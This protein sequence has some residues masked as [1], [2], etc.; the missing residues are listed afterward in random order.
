MEEEDSVAQP[1]EDGEMTARAWHLSLA[2]DGTGYCGWQVQDNQRTVQGELLKRLRLLFQSPELRLQG[3]SRTDSGVH[4]LDQHACFTAATSKDITPEWLLHKLNRW[5]PEDIIIKGVEIAP[6]GFNP[7]FD[8]F[9]KAYT[10]CISPGAKV[11]PMAARYVWK[12]PR[13]LDL[14]AMKKAAAYLEGEH[15]FA[16]FAANP[17]REIGSTVRKLYRLEV[18]ERGGLVFIVAVG[19][20]FLYKMVRGLAGY[21]AHVGFGYAASE[22]AL[23]VLEA[24]NRSAAADSAPSKGLFLARVFW[25]PDEWRTYEPVLPPFSI[26]AL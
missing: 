20:S 16:S 18:M 12:T 8:N 10:Y 13:P 22:D 25:K 26:D 6:D 23:A 9:G 4:A 15:D 3:C 17:G 7:R 11:N 19:E 1:V 5:L 2:Y 21:L 14:D 24:R